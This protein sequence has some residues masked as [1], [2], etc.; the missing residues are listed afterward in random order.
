MADDAVQEG[1]SLLCVREFEHVVYILKIHFHDTTFLA[2]IE[3][4]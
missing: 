4:E 3:H 2:S 1:F